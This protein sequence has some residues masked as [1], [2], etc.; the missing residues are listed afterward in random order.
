MNY[1]LEGKGK[2]FAITF[3]LGRVDQIKFDVGLSQTLPNVGGPL[4]FFR[5]DFEDFFQVY[6]LLPI[7]SFS[8]VIHPIFP[9]K[10]VENVTS[11][12]RWRD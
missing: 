12:L 8:R 10:I 9:W 2:C 1:K 3:G 6:V 11:S 5:L 4:L 7:Q